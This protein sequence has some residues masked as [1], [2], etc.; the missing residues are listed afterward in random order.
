MRLTDQDLKLFENLSKS[1]VGKSLIDYL[2]RLNNWLCDIRNMEGVEEEKRLARLEFAN[3]MENHFIKKIQL[4][5]EKKV[6]KRK[7]L[8][9]YE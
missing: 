4:S 1:N 6:D 9:E 3:I 7:E 5:N 8:K 2:T